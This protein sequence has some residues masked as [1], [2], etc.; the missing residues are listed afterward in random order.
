MHDLTRLYEELAEK[1]VAFMRERDRFMGEYD[2]GDYADVQRLENE[3]KDL[4][5]VIHFRKHG[6]TLFQTPLPFPLV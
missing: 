2:P 4:L 1:T 5:N 3:V 6:Q